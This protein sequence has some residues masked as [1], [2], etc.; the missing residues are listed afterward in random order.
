MYDALAPKSSSS[1][2]DAIAVG[3]ASPA[4]DFNTHEHVRP[5]C[6][7]LPS[8]DALTTSHASSLDSATAGPASPMKDF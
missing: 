6:G 4:M 8:F 7:R 1:P 5:Q 2:R 3:H